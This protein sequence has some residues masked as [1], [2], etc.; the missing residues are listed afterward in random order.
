MVRETDRDDAQRGAYRSQPARRTITPDR[1][2]APGPQRAKSRLK[3]HDDAVR[4]RKARW[5]WRQRQVI[6]GSLAEHYL[7]HARGY[8]GP[9]PATL[10]YFCRHVTVTHHR[11]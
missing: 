2:S 11:R 10:G 4:L 5:L 6:V 7:R 3:L 8:I 1:R 9:L